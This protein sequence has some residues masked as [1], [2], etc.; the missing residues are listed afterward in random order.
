MRVAV[1]GTSLF[2]DIEG[3]GL[4]P[5]GD[6]MREKPTLLLLHGG[7]GHD[8]TMFKPAYSRLADVAQLVYVDH[9]G[10]GRSQDSDPAT[11]HMDQWGDDIRALCD[12][13]GI[14]KP[15]VLGWSFGGTV[16]M[17]Y[18]A[19]YPDHPA[20]LVLQSTLARMDIDRVVEGFRTEAGE[21]AAAAAKGLLTEGTP[22][23]FAAFAEHCLAAYSPEPSFPSPEHAQAFGR[24]VL[25]PELTMSF[26]STEFDRRDSLAAVRCPTLVAAGARDPITPL[27]AADEIMAGLPPAAGARLEV[28]EHSGHF[29]PDSEGDR[30]FALLRAFITE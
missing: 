30:F 16:A 7:P 20:K 8:H 24:M 27:A 23:S 26:M 19:R 12:V 6:G 14:T 22:A 13:L 1:N 21:D 10:N 15:I 4:V 29:I 5:D 25:N 2:V 17:N 3:P 18:A 28:F 11:W 9:R